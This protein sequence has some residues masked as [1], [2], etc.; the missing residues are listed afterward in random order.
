[1]L[2]TSSVGVGGSP[3]SVSRRRAE[4]VAWCIYLKETRYMDDGLELLRLTGGWLTAIGPGGR[5]G[6]L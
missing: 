1:M 5:P 3:L 6:R 4:L 2:L